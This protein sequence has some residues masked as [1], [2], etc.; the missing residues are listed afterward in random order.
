MDEKSPSLREVNVR[1][2]ECKDGLS[3]S[4]TH[5]I[6]KGPDKL[7]TLVKTAKDFLGDED[8]KGKK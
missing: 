2:I 3:S 1:K 8:G 5:V 6:I 4:E 7:E